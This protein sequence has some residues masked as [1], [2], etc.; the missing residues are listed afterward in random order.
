M[1]LTSGAFAVLTLRNL[2]F[3]AS[4]I[5]DYK[6]CTGM[7]SINLSTLLMSASIEPANNSGINSICSTSRG[8]RSNI[9]LSLDLG[10]DEWLSLRVGDDDFG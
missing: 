4:I 7:I 1:I 10:F 9:V 5:S 8:F 3:I 6:V 2:S